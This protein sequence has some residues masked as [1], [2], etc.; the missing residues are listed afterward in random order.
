MKTD[1]Y[2]KLASILFACSMMALVVFIFT[3]YTITGFAC[4]FILMMSM[5]Y[6]SEYQYRKI[7]E[8]E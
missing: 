2:A 1:H 3:L 5:I 6:R 8:M 7:M 4:I